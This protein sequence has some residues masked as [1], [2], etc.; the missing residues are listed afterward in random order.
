M[1]SRYLAA[2]KENN[3]LGKEISEI[4]R[5]PLIK[6]PEMHKTGS[7]SWAANSSVAVTFGFL[8][9]GYASV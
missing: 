4:I 6:T 7:V 3:N 9:L 8:V 2:A 5:K 1:K